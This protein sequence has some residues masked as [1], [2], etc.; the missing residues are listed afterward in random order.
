M[1]LIRRATALGATDA[2]LDAALKALDTV[3]ML[4]SIVRELEPPSPAGVTL[5]LSVDLCVDAL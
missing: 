2:Q 4:L 3:S 1:E 5:H